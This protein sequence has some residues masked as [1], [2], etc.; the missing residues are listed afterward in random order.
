LDSYEAERAPHVRA[1]IHE[2]MRLGDIVQVTDPAEVAAR[3]R[4]MAENPE[5]LRTIAPRLGPGLGGDSPVPV[6]TLAPQPRLPGGE[7]MDDVVGMRFALL[8]DTTLIDA[9]PASL[10]TALAASDVVLVPDGAGDWLRQHGIRA[11]LLRPDRYVL[12]VARSASEVADLL[13]LLP[14]HREQAS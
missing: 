6:G 3:D 14:W 10:R 12:G 13:H 4:R 11:A 5:F 1:F 2:A 9:L 8:A 7:R